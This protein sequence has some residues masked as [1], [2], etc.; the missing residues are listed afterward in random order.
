MQSNRVLTLVENKL[1]RREESHAWLMGLTNETQ[2]ARVVSLGLGYRQRY[3]Y[4]VCCLVTVCTTV[5][6]RSAFY[7]LC[8]LRPNTRSRLPI[9]ERVFG[10]RHPYL[11]RCERRYN[12]SVRHIATNSTHR[13]LFITVQHICCIFGQKWQQLLVAT[14]IHHAC[15]LAKIAQG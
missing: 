15:E 14:G 2:F 5:F 9:L 1:R 13:K 3:S 11:S 12:N 10:L 6:L 7:R 8:F 4:P